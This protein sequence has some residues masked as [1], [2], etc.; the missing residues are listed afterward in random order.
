MTTASSKGDSG[1]L[2]SLVSSS[3]CTIWRFASSVGGIESYGFGISVSTISS[4]GS[5][6]TEESVVMPTSVRVVASWVDH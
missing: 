6:T 2:S 1:G 3:K 4:V 5:S